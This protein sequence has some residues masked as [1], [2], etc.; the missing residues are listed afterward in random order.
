MEL[1]YLSLIILI[2]IILIQIKLVAKSTIGKMLILPIL[3]SVIFLIS[4]IL[5]LEWEMLTMPLIVVTLLI[6]ILFISGLFRRRVL[7][8]G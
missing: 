7:Q 8:R 1:L 3:F 6:W 4:Y 2:A 5:K